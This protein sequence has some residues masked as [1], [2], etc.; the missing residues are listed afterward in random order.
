MKKVI[1]IFICAMMVLMMN[2]LTSHA[3]DSIGFSGSYT[4]SIASSTFTVHGSSIYC[5]YDI[6]PIYGEYVSSATVALQY[7]DNGSWS[8]FKS[9]EVYVN[10][11]SSGGS[12]NFGG[13]ITGTFRVK[14]SCSR[15]V[16]SM[17]GVVSY[18]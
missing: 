15:D 7:Y 17:S 11:P 3:S 6:T 4:D 18:N 2:P 14:I 16:E 5:T 10:Y 8:D 13:L 9:Q 12:V 1:S